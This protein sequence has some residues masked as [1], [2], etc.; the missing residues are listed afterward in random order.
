MA[1]MV[2][3][4]VFGFALR[5]RRISFVPQVIILLVWV[6]LFLLGVEVGSNPRV[7]GSLGSL[8][9]EALVLAVAGALGSAVLCKI[10]FRKDGRQWLIRS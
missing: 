3:G 10:V 5:R 6:L 4:L 8:G 7:V 2:A 9:V 1:F